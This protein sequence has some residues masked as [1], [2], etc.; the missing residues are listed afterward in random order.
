VSPVVLFYFCCC[1]VFIVSPEYLILWG[2]VCYSYIFIVYALIK[3]GGCKDFI[4]SIPCLGV[5]SLDVH[6]FISSLSLFIY[7]SIYLSL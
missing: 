7:S 4:L 3:R 5:H 1:V 2:F 6:S